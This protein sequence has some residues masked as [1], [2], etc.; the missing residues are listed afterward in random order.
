MTFITLKRIVYTLGLITIVGA[1]AGRLVKYGFGPAVFRSWAGPVASIAIMSPMAVCF[2]FM[3]VSGLPGG[4]RIV[5]LPGTR[6]QDSA[7]F[8]LI[9]T[10]FTPSSDIGELVPRG[11]PGASHEYALVILFT[12]LLCVVSRV[13]QLNMGPRMGVTLADGSSP[14]V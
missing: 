12:V 7:L 9:L 11:W 5:P 8:I 13:I 2:G 10:Q 4:R 1:L 6:Y 3:L 14:T